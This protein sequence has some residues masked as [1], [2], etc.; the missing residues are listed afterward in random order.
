MVKQVSSSSSTRIERM[1]MW[2]IFFADGERED[3]EVEKNHCLTLKTTTSTKRHTT[4]EMGST[5]PPLLHSLS[6]DNPRLYTVS[7]VRD[8]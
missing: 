7:R 4:V 2:R 5:G 8:T 6:A 3:A 1:Q